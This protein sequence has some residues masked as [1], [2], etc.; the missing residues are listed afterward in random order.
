MNHQARSA[1]RLPGLT[2]VVI[3]SACLSACAVLQGGETPA[4]S[5]EAPAAAAAPGAAASAPEAGI[6]YRLS[7]EAPDELKKMLQT[8]LDLARFQNAPQ[9]GGITNAELVRLTNASP[10]QARQLLE[11]EGYFNAVVTVS[12]SD[13]PDDT[14]LI[15][16]Q[17]EPGPHIL[18]SEWELKLQGDLQ[19]RADAGDG[20][21]LALIA[22]LSETWALQDG[23]PFSQSAWRGAKNAALALLRTEGYAT[24]ELVDSMARVDVRSNSVALAMQIE[25]GPLFHLGELRI[26]GVNHY[27]EVSIRN[28]A[29]FQ[30]GMP[31]SEKRLLDYQERL[32]KIGLYDSASVEIDPSRSAAAATPVTV[33][34]REKKLQEA[35]AGVGYSDSTEERFTLE[36]VHHRPFGLPLQS[37]NKL[38][39]GRKERLWEGD[40]MGD[41]NEDL[42][43]RLLAGG[44]SR[45]DTDTD[46]TFSWHARAGRSLTT[47]RIERLIYGEYVYATVTNVTGD[48]TS[49]AVSANYNWTWRQLDSVL[50]PTRGLTT[51]IQLAGGYALSND[52]DNGPFTRLYTRNT[53]YWP[54]GY[55]W[56]SQVR[57]EFAEVFTKD[58]VGI[59]DTLLFRAGGDDSVRGYGYRDLGPKIKD[60]NGN[61]VLV[62]GRK[63]VT[64]SLEIA[65]PISEKQPSIW[66]AA[67]IDAGNA[68]DQW[69]DFDPALGYGLGIRWRSPVGPLRI[70]V[71][72]GQQVHK[73]RLHF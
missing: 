71:A 45:V 44:I 46:S 32:N 42:Y 63:M 38:N 30:P 22:K 19:D 47:E 54:L 49:R 55:S 68:A 14:P 33:R 65:R 67:F 59:P 69:S 56:H 16:M 13:P 36:H 70:D 57:L 58:S 21:A 28:L 62:S 35:V 37:R 61:E 10:S 4:S 3:L 24:V 7:I 29:Q 25:S 50:L 15:E 31:Y 52:R 64:T 5:S 2:A 53:L 26:E 51:I 43:R 73:A 12:R 48:S 6:A 40:L 8:Y 41:P 66:W 23:K 72:Y 1:W 9:T 11:T 60:V 20:A 18:V 27:G 39:L 17:V 34:V